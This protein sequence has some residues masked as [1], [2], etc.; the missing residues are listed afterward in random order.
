MQI[1]ISAIAVPTSNNKF[2]PH[3]S[4]V[5]KIGNTMTGVNFEM[6]N[7]NYFDTEE[8]ALS[9]ARLMAESE[10]KKMYGNDIDFIFI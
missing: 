2:Y 8:E 7:I 10:V 4:F 5:E 6:E 3:F 9:T 1:I